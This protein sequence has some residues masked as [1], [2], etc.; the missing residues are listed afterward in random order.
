MALDVKIVAG[1][2]FERIIPCHGVCGEFRRIRVQA[3]LGGIQDVIEKDA[4]KAWLDTWKHLYKG[5]VD[6]SCG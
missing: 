6:P 3:F 5:G 1:W 4:K 2:D